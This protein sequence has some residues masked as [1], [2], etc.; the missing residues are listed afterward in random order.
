M[1]PNYRDTLKQIMIANR[2]GNGWGKQSRN[3]KNIKG[4]SNGQLQQR[5]P[6]FTEFILGTKLG[7]GPSGVI[8]A[9]VR[10]SDFTALAVKI[11]DKSSIKN[12]REEAKIRKEARLLG[13]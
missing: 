7:E 1:Y 5:S 6:F 9:C 10:R 11:I 13:V 12:S 4:A 3:N 2:V 8:K